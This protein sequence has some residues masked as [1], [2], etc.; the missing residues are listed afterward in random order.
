MSVEVNSHA[1]TPFP[2]TSPTLSVDRAGGSFLPHYIK[3]LPGSIDKDDLR[4]LR[5]RGCFT[6]LPTE[7]EKI[8]LCRYAEFIH[9][10]VP[11]LDLDEFIG[12]VLGNLPKKISILLYHAVMC[13]GLAAVEVSTIHE[14]GFDSK[15]AARKQYYTKAKVLFDMDVDT[16]SIVACQAA[17]LLISW[18]SY[19]TCRDPFYW[20]GVAISQACSLKIH[21]PESDSNT[22]R[23]DQ[24]LRQRI[25][26]TIIIKEC[27][28]CL[29][30]GR[31]PRISPQQTAL[32]QQHMFVANA[33]VMDYSRIPEIGRFRD[34][35]W[36]QR[37]L[38]MA[39]IEKAKLTTI[40]YR[41]LR[42][43]YSTDFTVS[44]QNNRNARIWQLESE[45]KDWR[46][47]LPM[48][49][50]P[51][52]PTLNLSEDVDKSLQV[53]MSMLLLSQLMALTMLHKSRVSIA[54]WAKCLQDGDDDWFD[55]EGVMSARAHTKSMRRAAYEITAIHRT[56]HERKLTSSIP[57]TGIATMCTAVFVHLLDARSAGGSIRSA[58]LEHLEACL[59]ILRELGQL[60]EAA[61]D[62]TKIVESA[63]QAARD[64]NAQ[65]QAAISWGPSST[66]DRARFA[67]ETRCTTSSFM[68]GVL[69][70]QTRSQVP[71]STSNSR[72]LFGST[73]EPSVPDLFNGIENFFDFELIE[74]VSLFTGA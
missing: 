70:D 34:D 51:C 59:T 30:L 54:E 39:Y 47:Q 41:I 44:N 24:M 27:D 46:L 65:P 13:A 26:W 18:G 7:L 53:T 67:N 4:Y 35:S 69:P 48:E 49:L 50:T 74:N 72:G 2:L 43:S 21:K 63:V 56:L 42:L 8:V 5:A 37:R 12:I 19:Q 11:V 1:G 62:V 6:F 32:P 20:L 55:D 40:I 64:L 10:L 38:E 33:H 66:S 22:P 9:P 52:N 61:T 57:T 60:N 28:V 73:A 45:L 15:P 14:Y 25:W 58:A 36:I 71:V 23:S 31:P 17:M 68:E 29:T 16:D 3:P